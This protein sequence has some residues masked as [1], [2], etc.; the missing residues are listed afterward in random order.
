M[1]RSARSASVNGESMYKITKELITA[2]AP[3]Q[4]AVLDKNAELLSLKDVVSYEAPSFFQ[5]LSHS[6]SVRNKPNIAPSKSEIYSAI[7]ALPSSKAAGVVGIPSDFYKAN[8]DRF[9]LSSRNHG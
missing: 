6:N 1:A 2:H 8:P 5:D 7:K 4:Q 3:I 9:T